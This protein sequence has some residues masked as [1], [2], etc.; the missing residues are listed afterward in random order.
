[1]NA[2]KIYPGTVT[3][4]A[5]QNTTT[6]KSELVKDEKAALV[7]SS[8]LPSFL[9]RKTVAMSEEEKEKKLLVIQ[10]LKMQKQQASGYKNI[11]VR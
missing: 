10:R 8:A 4:P 6:G 5:R 3:R 11:D 1:M 7:R 2:D 9:L